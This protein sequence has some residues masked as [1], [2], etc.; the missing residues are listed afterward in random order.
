MAWGCPGP[1][2][3][4]SPSRCAHWI[5][6]E[7]PKGC[8]GCTRSL[9]KVLLGETGIDYLTI[10]GEPKFYTINPSINANLLHLLYSFTCK[11]QVTNWATITANSSHQVNKARKAL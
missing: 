4:G 2:L 11:P 6:A 5:G 3:G 1:C 10:K 7:V 9:P 8:P